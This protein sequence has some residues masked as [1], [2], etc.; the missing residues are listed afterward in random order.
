MTKVVV[1]G[2]DGGKAAWYDRFNR[3]AWRCVLSQARRVSCSAR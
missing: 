2:A 3:G 1:K